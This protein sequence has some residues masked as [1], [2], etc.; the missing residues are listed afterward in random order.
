MTCGYLWAHFYPTYKPLT[1]S[2]TSVL[3]PIWLGTHTRLFFLLILKRKSM[4][5]HYFCFPTI[6]PLLLQLL[7]W[8]RCVC[9]CV[10]VSVS[11]DDTPCV[12]NE[13]PVLHFDVVSKSYKCRL[14]SLDSSTSRLRLSFV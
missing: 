7:L 9:L 8:P 12:G 13:F 4:M 5:Q 3:P 1:H 11:V 2:F 10:S 14:Y 6:G